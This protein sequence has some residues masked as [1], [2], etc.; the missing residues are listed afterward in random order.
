MTRYL[1]TRR[2]LISVGVIVIGFVAMVALAMKL[3]GTA[4][5]G[6]VFLSYTAGWLIIPYCFGLT[7]G[8]V[9]LIIFKTGKKAL[10][11]FGPL[12][13]V[14]LVILLFFGVAP[15][16]LPTID[17]TTSAPRILGAALTIML[18]VPAVSAT[19]ASLAA[20][21][22]QSINSKMSICGACGRDL[23]QNTDAFCPDCGTALLAG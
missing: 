4:P 19:I 16:E 21:L 9:S 2:L 11:V 22:W 3:I 13:V 15:S 5:E 8:F 18:F 12:A 1:L 17:E 14:L 23:T 7:V 6:K 10:C 20:L